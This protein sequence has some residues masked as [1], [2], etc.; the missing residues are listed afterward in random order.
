MR[1]SRNRQLSG[2]YWVTWQKT[3]APNSKRVDD[4]ELQFRAKVTDFIK[5]LRAAGAKVD[6]KHTLRT[7]QAAYLWD[8]AWQIAK[9]K[10]RPKDAKPYSGPLPV[11]DIEWDHG[12]DANSI[13]AANEMVAGFE[14]IHQPSPK[15]LH[16]SGTAI[17]MKI[18]W[19]GTID[20]KKKDGSKVSIPYMSDVNAN[21]DLHTVGASYGVIKLTNDK[22]HWSYNGH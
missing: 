12:N 14:L 7:P 20:V 16:L 15:S 5:A 10:A 19:T 11:P 2:R 17:D 4:L 22:P 21:T 8:W 18:T 13:K 6:E 3:Y 9:G 1:P